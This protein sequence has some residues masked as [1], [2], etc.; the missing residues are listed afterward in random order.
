[1]ASRVQ[2]IWKKFLRRPDERIVKAQDRKR[3]RRNEKKYVETIG[4]SKSSLCLNKRDQLRSR[5]P[6][7]T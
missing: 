5:K 6:A 1:M 4:V 3:W 7:D 2:E